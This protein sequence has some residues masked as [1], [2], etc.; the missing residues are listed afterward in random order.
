LRNSEHRIR[1]EKRPVHFLIPESVCQI[2][3][4]PFPAAQKALFKQLLP[5]PSIPVFARC[6]ADIASAD[7]SVGLHEKPVETQA[8][9]C[10]NMPELSVKIGI[11][12][13]EQPNFLFCIRAFQAVHFVDPEINLVREHFPEPAEQIYI[14]RHPNCAGAKKDT[15]LPKPNAF[16]GKFFAG[17]HL[18]MEGS[19][20][21]KLFPRAPELIED[22]ERAFGREAQV[23]LRSRCLQNIPFRQAAESLPIPWVD[24]G[25]PV[26]YNHQ[27]A[28][29]QIFRA[30]PQTFT[31]PEPLFPVIFQFPFRNP[32]LG[33][34]AIA[35]LIITAL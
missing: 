14:T 2:T 22:F 4:A 29:A 32:M 24:Q 7:I 26:G 5:M 35:A 27:G 17:R 19:P 8:F 25:F 30:F 20:E 28:D 10:G 1:A 9:I 33:K 15:F 13:L 21:T 23:G 11:Y 34:R 6:P 12:G 3:G 18:R 16:C 31:E